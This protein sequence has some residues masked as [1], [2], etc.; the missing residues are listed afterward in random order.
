M[1]YFKDAGEHN[2]TKWLNLLLTIPLYLMM[3]SLGLLILNLKIRYNYLALIV[4]L[5]SIINIGLEYWFGNSLIKVIIPIV[6]MIYLYSYLSKVNIL[7]SSIAIIMGVNV[8]FFIESITTLILYNLL[9]ICPE[10]Y[11]NS[12]L[13]NVFGV[14]FMLLFGVG[15]IALIKTFNW[16]L[17]NLGTIA[18][19]SRQNKSILTTVLFVIANHF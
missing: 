5:V 14:L 18:E 12:L 10:E 17:F 13:V 4:I 16:Q 7:K 9:K 19:N 8:Y 6:M 15:I 2:V 11:L 1:K 3:L